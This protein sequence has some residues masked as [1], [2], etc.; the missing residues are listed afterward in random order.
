TKRCFSAARPPRRWR[1]RPLRR[2]P[3]R[4]PPARPLPVQR[5]R[6]GLAPG[7][8]QARL[9]AERER[10]G[11]ISLVSSFHRFLF[12]ESRERRS[13]RSGEHRSQGSRRNTISEK[14]GSLLTIFDAKRG[15]L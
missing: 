10:D 8:G 15:E 4:L 13:G 2:W 14:K 1:E 3:A 5:E 6:Q 9:R 7:R 11:T 12:S